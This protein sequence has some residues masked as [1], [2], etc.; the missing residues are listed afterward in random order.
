[1]KIRITAGGIFGAD[2]EVKIGTEFD[3]ED[4]PTGWDGRYEVVG[5]PAAKDAKPVTNPAGKDPL[6]HD[7]DGRKGGAAPAKD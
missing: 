1:M 4:V 6:D 2:G 3:V 5:K 7:G